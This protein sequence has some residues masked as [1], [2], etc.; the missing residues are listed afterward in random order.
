MSTPKNKNKM[1]KKEKDVGVISTTKEI[2][3]MVTPTTLLNSF[4]I[5]TYLTLIYYNPQILKPNENSFWLKDSN[6]QALN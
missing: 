6:V 5:L 1:Y 2:V 4:L 3:E